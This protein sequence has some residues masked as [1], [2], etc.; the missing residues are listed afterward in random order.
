MTPNTLMLERLIPLESVDLHS[1]WNK[2][3]TTISATE[4][5]C[6]AKESAFFESIPNPLEAIRAVHMINMEHMSYKPFK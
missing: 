2:L 4:L 6:Q 3:N 5:D 1:T